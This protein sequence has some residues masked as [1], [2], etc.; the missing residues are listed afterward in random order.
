MTIFSNFKLATQS[1]FLI[2]GYGDEFGGDRAVGL[3]VADAIENWHLPAIKTIKTR[4]LQPALAEDL[5]AADY[6]VFID[7]CGAE[8]CSRT[9]Q[10]DP[11]AVG[12]QIPRT[13]LAEKHNCIPLTLLNLTQQLYGRTP[14]AWLLQVPTESFDQR[15]LSSTAQRGLD[16]A[17]RIVAQL[18]K[19][20]QQPGWI[21]SAIDQ[22]VDQSAGQP[23]L[24]KSHRRNVSYSSV[25]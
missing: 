2:I 17:V 3:Q 20:Y 10:L 15:A 11:V 7:A 1:R 14:Q 6:A 18:L 5:V 24:V 4:Q 23:V 21:S 19:T 9:V 16:R 22:P 25:V 13:L 8:N 12:S